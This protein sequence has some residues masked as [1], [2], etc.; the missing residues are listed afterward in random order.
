MKP[1]LSYALKETRL[2]NDSIL[3]RL[4]NRS[5]CV[6]TKRL[7]SQTIEHVK[8]IRKI[9][10]ALN[11]TMRNTNDDWCSSPTILTCPQWSS[12]TFIKS[13]GKSNYSSNGSNKICASNDFSASPRTLFGAKSGSQ[14]ASMQSLQSLKNNSKSTARWPKFYTF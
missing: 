1:S 9:S 7:F 12:P 4:I 11:I 13:V 6:A 2:L 14:L 8:R 3:N 10:V 5:V